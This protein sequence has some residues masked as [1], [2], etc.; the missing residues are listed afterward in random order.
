MGEGIDAVPGV[1]GDGSGLVA[2]LPAFIVVSSL[3][4]DR[5]E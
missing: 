1:V 4:P 2:L 5:H 3:S